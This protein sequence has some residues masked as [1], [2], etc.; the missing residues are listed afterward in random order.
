MAVQVYELLY[1]TPLQND[2][3][4]RTAIRE[5]VTKVLQDAGATIAAARDF[6]RQRLAYPIKK[7]QAGEY[8]IVDFSAANNATRGIERELRLLSDVLRIM[9]TRKLEKARSV[10]AEIEAKERAKETKAAAADTTPTVSVAAP[11]REPQV[12]EDLDKKLEEI[13]GKEMI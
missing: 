7:Q 3:A 13:L 12:I 10:G 11:A 8:V 4:A 6:A 2:D 5:R 9:V 1:I